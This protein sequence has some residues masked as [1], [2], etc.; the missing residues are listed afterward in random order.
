MKG[1]DKSEFDTRGR[2]KRREMGQRKGERDAGGGGRRRG[3]GR[4]FGLRQGGQSLI[5][6][7]QTTFFCFSYKMLL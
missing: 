4:G 7:K 5:Y 2:V 3:L 6:V 1:K